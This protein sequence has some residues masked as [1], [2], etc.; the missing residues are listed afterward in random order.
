MTHDIQLYHKTHTYVCNMCIKEY[1]MC[2]N[3]LFITPHTPRKP[4]PQKPYISTEYILLYSVQCL[5]IYM[6]KFNKYLEKK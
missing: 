5:C 3:L 6:R 1:G 4:P 2:K